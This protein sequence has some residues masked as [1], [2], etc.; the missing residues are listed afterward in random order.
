MIDYE[1]SGDGPTVVLVHGIA[2][3]RRMCGTHSFLRSP[4]TTA[5]YPWTCAVTANPSD[6]FPTM[7]W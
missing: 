6:G 4:V 2:Q 3:S 7:R 1:V 5:S